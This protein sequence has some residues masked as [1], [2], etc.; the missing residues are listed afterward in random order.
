MW[1]WVGKAM[2]EIAARTVIPQPGTFTRSSA[3]LETLRVVRDR[4]IDRA[5]EWIGVWRLV[6]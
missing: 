5:A 6:G 4:R 1:S 2:R 3:S